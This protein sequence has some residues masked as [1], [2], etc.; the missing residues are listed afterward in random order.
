MR[1]EVRPW[2]LDGSTFHCVWD[3]EKNE[4]AASPL[5]ITKRFAQEDADRL[6]VADIEG[7]II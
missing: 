7:G 2:Q 3:T 6:N 4:R 5:W 1:Y